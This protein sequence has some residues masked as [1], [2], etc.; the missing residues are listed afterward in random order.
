[1]S[2]SQACKDCKVLLVLALSTSGCV[3]TFCEV[4]S[5]H[6]LHWPVAS[7]FL[8]ATVGGHIVDARKPLLYHLG[9]YRF[10]FCPSVGRLTCAACALPTVDIGVWHF[11]LVCD[12]LMGLRIK[13]MARSRLPSWYPTRTLPLLDRSLLSRVT[14]PGPF[15]CCRRVLGEW[16]LSSR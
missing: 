9:G 1:M 5:L 12:D 15:L 2:L 10:W 13:W 6:P 3:R 11:T 14:S 7:L 8:V 16:A 4:C